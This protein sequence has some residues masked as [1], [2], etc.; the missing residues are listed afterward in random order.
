VAKE[1]ILKECAT[2][3]GGDWIKWHGSVAPYRKELTKA[4]NL[5]QTSPFVSKLNPK[6]TFPLISWKSDPGHV[7]HA[8]SILTIVSA[9]DDIDAYIA[10][11][12]LVK[13]ASEMTKWFKA[14]GID[15]IFMPVPTKGE[16][17]PEEL[18][19]DGSVVPKDLNVLPHMRKKVL[20][21]LEEG[22]E[23][24]DLYPGLMQ[25]RRESDDCL[26]MAGDKHWRARPQRFA[27]QQIAARLS[28]YPWV[29][30]AQSR[31]GLFKEVQKSF[32][33]P[34]GFYE[35]LPH[36]LL[37]KVQS[38]RSGFY[39]NNVP[40]NSGATEVL[41]E[42]AAVLVTGDSFVNHGYPFSGGLVGHLARSI[43]EPVRV[44]QV[45]GNIVQTF[46]DFF[47]DPGLLTKTK[48]VVWVMNDEPFGSNWMV[49]ERFKIPQ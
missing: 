17:Y 33:E 8:N 36:S 2:A 24:I 1:Q 40:V 26:Y 21:M 44:S 48:V 30:K 9:G 41:S 14:R 23:V 16:V 45:A 18:V 22:V 38:H 47:R 5:A 7:V 25:L 42:S 13:I 46:Q 49:P 43:N 20:R 6:L 4:Y 10:S 15:L 27:A 3:A 31:P 37:F 39:F 19:A 28:R 12:R 35:F 34:V 11:D 32:E 29:A